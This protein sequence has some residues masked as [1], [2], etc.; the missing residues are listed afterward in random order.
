MESKAPDASEPVLRRSWWQRIRRGV[1]L[2]VC[3][4]YVSVVVVFVLFQRRLMYRPTV[5][6]NLSV[7]EAGL[8]PSFARDIQLQPADGTTLN[9]WLVNHQIGQTDGDVEAPLLIYFPGNSLNRYERISD[10]REVAARGFDV[11]CLAT[12]SFPGWRQL[13]V[14]VADCFT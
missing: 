4:P 12:I 5:S 9:S 14:R 7:T 8:D 11:L 6:D 2:Y 10:L 13:E 1:L 3:L